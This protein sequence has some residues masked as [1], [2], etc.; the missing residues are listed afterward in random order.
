MFL[1]NVK[2]LDTFS[3]FFVVAGGS[4]PVNTVKALNYAREPHSAS[5]V[6]GKTYKRNQTLQAWNLVGE[7]S[8]LRWKFV[9]TAW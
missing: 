2:K 3:T 6:W 4:T 8:A 1:E 5:T 7:L 9:R